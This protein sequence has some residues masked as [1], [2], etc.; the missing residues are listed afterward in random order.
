MKN[1]Y[2]ILRTAT[3]DTDVSKVF[4][5]V[6]DIENWN[7]W[8]KSVT[9]ISFLEKFKFEVGG[10]ARVYQ[11]KLLPAVWTITEIIENRS[12]VWQTKSFTVKMTAK[13]IL[14]GTG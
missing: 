1:S 7:L 10:K 9:K 13:H 4:R 12:F 5:V 8:T 11:P 3:I 6:A 14:E 2:C